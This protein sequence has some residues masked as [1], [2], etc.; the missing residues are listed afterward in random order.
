M[1]SVMIHYVDG[2]PAVGNGIQPD[3]YV[4]PTIEGMMNMKDEVLEKAIEYA[5]K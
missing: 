3:I 1:T 2:T 5:K 4:E